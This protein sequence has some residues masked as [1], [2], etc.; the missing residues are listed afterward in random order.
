[1]FPRCG[2]FGSS[3]LKK[4]IVFRNETK[5]NGKIKCLAIRYIF[6]DCLNLHKENAHVFPL[7]AKSGAASAGQMRRVSFEFFFE[8]VCCF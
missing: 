5:C 3:F 4:C 7:L 6:H 1:M 8:N 2:E